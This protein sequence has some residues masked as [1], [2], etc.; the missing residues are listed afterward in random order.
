MTKEYHYHLELRWRNLSKTTY[1]ITS[2]KTQEYN[3]FAWAAGEN[4]RHWE[5]DPPDYYYWP[6]NVPNEATLDAYIQAYQTIGYQPCDSE[7]LE[8][9]YEKIAIYVDNDKIPTHAARQ[10]PNGKWTSKLGWLEDIEHEL[11]GLEGDKY[12]TVTQIL[13]R[14][15]P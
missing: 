11:E 6:E 13:K 5:H 9:N 15:K 12:G 1:Q 7:K 14:F 4:D 3:C 8:S 2:P 10:L